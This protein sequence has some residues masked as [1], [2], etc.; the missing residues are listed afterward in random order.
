M[1][2]AM[3]ALLLVAITACR[4]TSK[5]AGQSV[6]VSSNEAEAPK[7]ADASPA[8]DT[9]PEAPSSPV[10]DMVGVL[11]P[12]AVREITEKTI[13]LDSLKLAQVAVVIIDDLKGMKALDYATALGNKWGVGHKETNDGIKDEWGPY[14]VRLYRLSR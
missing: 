8:S 3:A 2:V 7:A 1:K 14:G 11:S 12:E 6:Q 10:L 4:D 13:E 5:S 9:L